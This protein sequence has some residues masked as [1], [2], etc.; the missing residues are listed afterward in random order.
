MKEEKK[1]ANEKQQQQQNG[2]WNTFKKETLK[3]G[4]KYGAKAHNCHSNMY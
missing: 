1:I 2:L 3:K 4:E